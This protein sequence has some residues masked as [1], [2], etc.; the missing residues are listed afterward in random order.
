MKTCLGRQDIKR[1]VFHPLYFFSPRSEI[2]TTFN[3]L[4]WCCGLPFPKCCLS[5]WARKDTIL[6][7]VLFRCWIKTRAPVGIPYKYLQPNFCQ[8]GNS[9]LR[10]SAC[11]VSN[12]LLIYQWLTWIMILR[13]TSTWNTKDRIWFEECLVVYRSIGK[14]MQL[15]SHIYLLGTYR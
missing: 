13:R 2:S 7:W 4:G 6:P 1:L 12:S 9:N 14:R 15:I 10:P 3:T 11:Q 5:R 8:L